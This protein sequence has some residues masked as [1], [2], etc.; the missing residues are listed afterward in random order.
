MSSSSVVERSGRARISSANEEKNSTVLLGVALGVILI[1]VATLALAADSLFP[2][3]QRDIRVL[4]QMSAY[5]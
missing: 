3:G 2:S 5:P 1:G 4:E